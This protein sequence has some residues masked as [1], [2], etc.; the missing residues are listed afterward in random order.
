MATIASAFSPGSGWTGMAELLHV[1]DEGG[2]LHGGHEG[3]AQDRQPLRRDLLR[4]D[5]RPADLVAATEH[6]QERALLVGLGEGADVDRAL[7][8]LLAAFR[9]ETH[10]GMD[11]LLIDP[12]DRNRCIGAAVAV[13]LAALDGDALLGAAGE[14]EDLAYRRVE[15]L[16]QRRAVDVV[17]GALSGRAE[18]ELLAAHHLVPGLHAVR[19]EAVADPVVGGDDADPGEVAEIDLDGF[20]LHD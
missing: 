5:E 17:A 7:R 8:D 4:H 10:E 12:G 13:E 1:G 16:T 20:R 2:I 3:L 15:H 6:V 9:R 18:D 19:P 14:T 11:L